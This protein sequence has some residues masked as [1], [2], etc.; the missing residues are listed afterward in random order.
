MEL[1][2]T[3]WLRTGGPLIDVNWCISDSVLY[4]LADIVLMI[5]RL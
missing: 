3:S 1:N 2:I 4:T 5:E